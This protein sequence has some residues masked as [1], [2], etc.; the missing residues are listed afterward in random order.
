MEAQDLIDKKMAEIE[1]MQ[2]ELKEK[3]QDIEVMRNQL[4]E[5]KL[6]VSN[7]Q[8]LLNEQMKAT[9]EEARSYSERIAQLESDLEGKIGRI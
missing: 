5:C 6:Q 9:E 7:S 2:Y 3:D 4:F 8:N 1:E